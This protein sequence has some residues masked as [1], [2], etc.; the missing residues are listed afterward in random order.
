MSQLQGG[1]FLA[2]TSSTDSHWLNKYIHPL[3]QSRVLAAIAK[4]IETKQYFE[5]EPRVLLAD[6]TLG[7]TFSRAVPTLND[8]GEFTEWFEAAQDITDP[9]RAEAILRQSEKLAAVGQLASTTA[10]E[11]NSDFA[12][13]RMPARRSFGWTGLLKIS[14]S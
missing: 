10:H 9:K 12:S 4:A 2:D 8:K 3:D 11:I 7:W 1:K 5:L 6:G 14:D 13:F